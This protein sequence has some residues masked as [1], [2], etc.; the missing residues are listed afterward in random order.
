[1]LVPA[2]DGHWVNENHA[3]IAELINDY[4]PSM[5]LVWI[6]PENRVKNG[7]EAPYAVRHTNKDGY[8]YLLFF[9]NDDELDHRVLGRI[10]EA[11]L[12]KHDVQ[13]RIES[14][15]KAYWA[16]QRKIRQEKAEE[17]MDFVR[18]VAGNNKST[19]KHNGKIYPT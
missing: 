16:L 12:T 7:N 10:Y 5:D 9:V 2:E 13:A 18:A 17:R 4:D 3:R 11:D 14:D 1:V 8:Q 15:E 6:P 19:F